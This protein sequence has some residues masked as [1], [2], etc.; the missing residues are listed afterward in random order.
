[1]KCRYRFCFLGFVF[2]TV[3]GFQTYNLCC[4]TTKGYLY[5]YDFVPAL[6][7]WQQEVVGGMMDLEPHLWRR[8]HKQNFDDQRRKVLQFGEWWKPFDWTQKIG[9]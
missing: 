2:P 7:P 8:P 9:K 3:Y 5:L 6:F 1:M 4:R